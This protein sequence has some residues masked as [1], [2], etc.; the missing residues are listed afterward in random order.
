MIITFNDLY[1]HERVNYFEIAFSEIDGPIDNVIYKKITDPVT[2]IVTYYK[3]A[4][5]GAIQVKWF[6]AKGDELLMIHF[7]L[8]QL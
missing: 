6:G 5:T 4:Y 8:K 1:T 3:R 2:N 7:L